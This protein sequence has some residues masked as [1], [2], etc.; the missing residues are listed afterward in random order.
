[1]NPFVHILESGVFP[2]AR[3]CGKRGSGNFGK[4]SHPLRVCFSAP[5]GTS[6][7]PAEG[8]GKTLLVPVLVATLLCLSFSRFFSHCSA[9]AS[10]R[11][12]LLNVWLK[13]FLKP[14]FRSSW[15]CQVSLDFILSLCVLQSSIL[16]AAV[17]ERGT[18]T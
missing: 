16:S 6:C 14:V 8:R 3:K 18:I 7:V 5:Q 17:S 15:C 2:Y 11:F 13:R 4:G 10:D 1:M 12:T 9:S